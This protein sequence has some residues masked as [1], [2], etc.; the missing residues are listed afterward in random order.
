MNA[1]I[2]PGLYIHI[3]F[4]ERKCPY[5]AFYS[6]EIHDSESVHRYCSAVLHEIEALP[7]TTF[8]TLYLGG[9]TP[10]IVPV[11]IMKQFLLNI[12]NR[13][14]YASLQEITVEI[15][16]CHAT[17]EYLQML[18]EA[19]VD[20]FSFG[21]QSFD[22]EKLITLGRLHTTADIERLIRIT[23][24]LKNWSV[25]LMF[26]LSKDTEL[27]RKELDTLITLRPPHISLYNLK[28][29]PDT[30]FERAVKEHDIEL[31]DD[32]TQAEHYFYIH[33]RLKKAGY[34]HY[35]I[36][37]FCLP[38]FESRHNMKYWK[39]TPWYAIGPSATSFDGEKLCTHARSIENYI[40]LKNSTSTEFLDSNDIRR[41]QIMMGLRTDSGVSLFQEEQQ[42][43][44]ENDRLDGFIIVRNN[45]L[46]IP[47][48][49]WFRS[50]SIIA[51]ILETLD[52]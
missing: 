3:P 6:K 51:E 34:H 19:G 28:I 29:E 11:E 46:V 15:N 48:E 40:A 13:I 32:D 12:F 2:L 36:S 39:M 27:V 1:D 43:V 26:G 4:C 23:P 22:S 21:V 16:P 45:T 33:E 44:C 10:S 5:C 50:N 24:L 35:E 52:M 7:V 9:G 8:D 41:Y 17:R 25:D 31:A 14:D 37:N 38:G 30:P 47:H 42:R 20:R 49:H 18:L